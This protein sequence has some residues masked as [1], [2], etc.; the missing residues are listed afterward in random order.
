MG[1]FENMPYTNFH[2]LNLD[3]IIEE[4][5][6]IREEWDAYREETSAEMAEFRA[7]F[8]NLDVSD[9]VRA[10]INDMVSS[11]QFLTITLPSITSVTESWLAQH[12]TQETGYV[13]D[14]TLTVSGAA[15]D[16]KAVGDNITILKSDLGDI[17]GLTPLTMTQ[18]KFI[19]TSVSPV[20]VTALHT[21]ATYQCCVAPC[22]EGDSFI[23]SSKS[24]T[25][26]RA[27]CFTDSNY[28][29]ISVANANV[30]LD[31]Q[32]I[33]AP[34]N[35]SWL[36]I[37][38]ENNSI[39]RP[40]YKGSLKLATVDELNEL[41]E[42]YIY[43]NKTLQQTDFSSGYW[44][45]NG[46]YSAATDSLFNKRI[47]IVDPPLVEEGAVVN[48]N[49][50]SGYN[51]SFKLFANKPDDTAQTALA[52]SAWLSGAST[53]TISHDGY[54]CVNYR[55]SNDA[56]INISNYL[57][58]IV[59]PEKAMLPYVKDLDERVTA[60]ENGVGSY[61]YYGE[62]IRLTPYN[63]AVN[64]MGNVAISGYTPQGACIYE[65]QLFQF[66][67][68]SKFSVYDLLTNTLSGI[69]SFDEATA[70]LHC[71]SACFGN[72]QNSTDAYP[73]LY[74]NS[75]LDNVGNGVC[76]VHKI[77]ESNG[78]YTTDLIQTIHIDFTD[79]TLWTGEVINPS[80][81]A[82]GNF[83]VD[84]IN[85]RLIA[86]VTQGFART[87]FFMFELP[88]TAIANVTLSTNN[89]IDYFDLAYIANIQDSCLHNGMIYMTAGINWGDYD[90]ILRI[91]VINLNGRSIVSEIHLEEISALNTEPEGIDYYDDSLVITQTIGGVYKLTF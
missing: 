9:E 37:N 27:W 41:S 3:W 29:T 18:G 90:Q 1:V 50:P 30:V 38:D 21:A 88:D 64:A 55:K 26:A 4:V 75:Y 47:S 61:N 46:K 72:K 85:N 67:A 73:L 12:I 25:A 76:E 84:T 28:N 79:N 45:A 82:N 63:F 62:K 68:W 51:V 34:D 8:D 44:L 78:T 49:I 86:Y 19:V 17:T 31:K 60:L 57:A 15:A 35:S 65:D 89:I 54:L 6:K 14:D 56:Q 77:T 39:Y 40:S 70:G 69:F 52:E 2:E 91:Y 7:W 23:I 20:D 11:G 87:R 5:K 24:G 32:E 71:N 66:Y 74:V 58:N 13:I 83:L 53:Y 16:A 36:I 22:Q 42:G 33:T 59:I 48:F 81:L 10:V 80:T 43:I